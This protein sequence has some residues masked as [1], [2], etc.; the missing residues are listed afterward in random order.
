MTEKDQEMTAEAAV[1]GDVVDIKQENAVLTRDLKARDVTIIRLEQTLAIK[2]NEIV[3]LKQAL[4]EVKW[5]LDEIGKALPEAIAAYKAL[6][7]QANPGVLAEL[8]TGDNV[9]QIDKSLKNA[10]ALVE[11]VRQEIEA[12]ASKTRVPAGAPQRT[13]LDMSSLS[14]REKI[15]YAIGGSPS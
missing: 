9:E 14:P 5:Q 12:E 11:R 13:P 2:E 15:K 3:T 1:D 10:R 8:I 7:V 6:I 4:A